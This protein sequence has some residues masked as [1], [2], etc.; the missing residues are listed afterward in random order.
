MMFGTAPIKTGKSN[1]SSVPGDDAVDEKGD[2]IATSEKKKDAVA[3]S[4]QSAR[5]V[6]VLRPSPG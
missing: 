1:L 5:V 3:S 6:I 4:G 2:A